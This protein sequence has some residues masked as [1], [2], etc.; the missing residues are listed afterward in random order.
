MT[1]G[2]DWRLLYGEVARMVSLW[3]SY[4][5]DKCVVS[6]PTK[7]I[8]KHGGGRIWASVG[9]WTINPIFLGVKVI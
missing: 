5:L 2:S 1:V 8:L 6:Y 3:N 7:F 9:L 4:A